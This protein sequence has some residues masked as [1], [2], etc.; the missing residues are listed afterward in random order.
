M[1][2]LISLSR[3][4]GRVLAGGGDSAGQ[5][6]RGPAAGSERALLLLLVFIAAQLAAQLPDRTGEA[7][8]LREA[9]AG[10]GLPAET[11]GSSC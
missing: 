11:A 1:S 6:H 4:F 2:E 3:G 8:Q 9:A 10:A 5:F 7:A